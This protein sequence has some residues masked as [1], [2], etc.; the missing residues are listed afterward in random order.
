MADRGF[1]ISEELCARRVKLNIPAFMKGRD[2]LSEHEVIETRRIASNRIHVERA[3]MRMKSYRLIN[4]KMVNKSLKSANKTLGV[5][6]ALCNLRDQLIKED[7][8]E[9]AD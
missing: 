8:D 3:I 7:Y 2:Q 1:T 6:A 4:T 5:V 9:I